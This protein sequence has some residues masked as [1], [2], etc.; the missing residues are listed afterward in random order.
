M[1]AWA[2]RLLG[3]AQG[4][5]RGR[6]SALNIAASQLT[7][8][9]DTLVDGV[10]FDARTSADELGYKALAVN[11]SDMAAMGA[12]PLG[13]LLALCASPEQLRGPWLESF[14]RGL[15]ELADTHH[16]TWRGGAIAEGPL[17]VTVEIFGQVRDAAVLRRDAA[18]RGDGIYV[19]GTLGDAGCASEADLSRIHASD[20]DFL[21]RRLKRPTPRISTGLALASIAHAAIDLSDGLSADLPHILHASK[22]GATINTADLPLS[23]PLLRCVGK[24]RGT[25]LAL[26]AGDDYELLL[27]I[28]A[29]AET[30]LNEKAKELDCPL[31][32]IGE[33]GAAHDAGTVRVRWLDER[34]QP[35]Q[36]PPGYAHFS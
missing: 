35:W 1:G 8:S 26:R 4:R 10:H 3:P 9:V 12:Q 28:P 7:V 13:A 30:K 6:A 32:R 15:L 19:T 2:D 27:T 34:G 17:S 31:T 21:E 23:T 18:V 24:D 33:I 36:P 25:A 11:L 20:R 14:A 22:V 29:D 5:H 16:L